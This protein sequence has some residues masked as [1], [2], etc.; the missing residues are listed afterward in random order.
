M[1]EGGESAGGISIGDVSCRTSTPLQS[2]SPPIPVA[3]RHASPQTDANGL[4][5]L[6]DPTEKTLLWRFRSYSAFKDSEV[7][8]LR[9]IPAHWHLKRLKDCVARLES[10]GTPESY[11]DRYWTDE[12][13]GIPWVAIS[14]MT[15]DFH[16]HTTTKRITEEG[17]RSKRLRVLP[18][19]TLLYSMYAS[20]GKVALLETEA[21]INQAILGVVPRSRMALRDYLRW[22]FE[23]MQAQVQMLSSSN[24]Q[25]NLSADRVRKMP[26]ALPPEI[27]EQKAIA[28]FLDRETAKIDALVAKKE[29]LVELL[30]EKRT[31]LI[32]R[33]VTR[34][35]DPSV[36][37]KD[38]GVE[39]LGEI[40]A[41]WDVKR[42]KW[43]SRMESGHTPDKKIAAYWTD[44]DVPW[45]S[46]NDTR[47]LKDHD[48]IAA[49]A[50]YTNEL[51]LRNSSARLLPPR[52]VVFSRDA[53][54]GLCAITECPMAV[55]QHF[56]AWICGTEVIP[57][58][59]LRVFDT[60]QGELER[61]TMGATL[62]T[63]GMPDVK[64]LTTPVPPIYEQQVIVRHIRRECSR[65]D[66]LVGKIH[67]AID[68]LKE[69]RTA[70]IAA[71]VTGKIDVR[72]EAA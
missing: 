43:V 25:D 9:E 26:V 41:H 37:M 2:P 15:R 56:I 55:S 10:G 32:T 22:W 36:P 65:L 64:T 67:Q 33:A 68:H 47:Y 18:A 23:F 28:A 35:L 34:G 52:A 38:S 59:L 62:R 57:E 61:L 46:L 69:Y 54:I 29:R 39:W 21:V 60:M 31:A 49:T 7:E 70:L 63:I 5:E 40:P 50:Y 6:T 19:G 1:G 58:Y 53:T 12:G 45:V 24:T 42:V 48:Y 66:L 20:L 30:Q 27:K 3:T 17:R 11:N 44:G 4:I 16:L 51:G 8:W 13:Q 72:N 71:A 14:D